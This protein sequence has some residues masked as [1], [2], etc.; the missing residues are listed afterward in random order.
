VEAPSSL[1]PQALAKQ[2]IKKEQDLY[3]PLKNRTYD[4]NWG[5]KAGARQVWV[6]SLKECGHTFDAVRDGLLTLENAIFDL[7]GGFGTYEEKKE[8]NETTM[9]TSADKLS[10]KDLLYDNVSRFDIELE[11]LGGQDVKGL[12]NSPDA[13]EVFKEII[14]ISKTVSILALGLELICRNAN[15]YIDRT[16]SSVVV[17]SAVSDYSSFATV[18]RR[19]AAMQPGGY[20]SFF[21]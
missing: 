14:R 18:G 3:M 9:L 16:K 12:W 13:R 5:G 10:G 1:T 21:T 17:Q 7:T 20:A 15:A 8:E 19:R 4:N 6:S 2:L 11:S